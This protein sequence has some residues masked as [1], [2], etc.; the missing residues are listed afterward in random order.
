MYSF[1]A[2][3]LEVAGPIIPCCVFLSFIPLW[4]ILTASNQS[5]GGMYTLDFLLSGSSQ[6][7][8]YGIV[9]PEHLKVKA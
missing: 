9:N 4:I 6:I 5:S 8:K 3:G 7:S 2:N 1:A